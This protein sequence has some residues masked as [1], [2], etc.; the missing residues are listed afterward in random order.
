MDIHVLLSTSLLS[1][2]LLSSPLLSL[3][4]AVS[5]SIILLL[6]VS[7]DRLDYPP[8]SDAIVSHRCTPRARLFAEAAQ[9]SP[10]RI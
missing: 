8:R 2:P 1:S 5:P 7:F 10:N 4:A 6:F 3:L 9:L